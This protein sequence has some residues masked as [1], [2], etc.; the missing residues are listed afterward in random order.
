ML[1]KIEHDVF[2][3]CCDSGLNIFESVWRSLG[4]RDRYSFSPFANISQ[5]KQSWL[6][7]CTSIRNRRIKLKV[8][9]CV[10]DKSCLFLGVNSHPL[11]V[12]STFSFLFLTGAFR[13][14]GGV[15]MW[16]SSVFGAGCLRGSA[17]TVHLKT[18]RTW[19]HNVCFIY[20]ETAWQLHFSTF[21]WSKAQ[22]L[23][24]HFFQTHKWY[25]GERPVSWRVFKRSSVC[26]GCN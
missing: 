18:A 10:C 13:A 16:S 11:G 1:W 25:G 22:N 6:F 12:W 3:F 26:V 2:S 24:S 23:N 5:I 21:H 7:S 20:E 9:V 19:K 14:D 17:Q 4:T 15:W 8:C